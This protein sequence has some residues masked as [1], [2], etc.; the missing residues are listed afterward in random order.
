MRGIEIK[1]RKRRKAFEQYMT[2]FGIV[3]ILV[4]FCGISYGGYRAYVGYKIST[5][6][7]RLELIREQERN[8]RQC[9]R[10]KC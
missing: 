5:T 1:R 2:A 3:I 9:G 7:E 4:A 6:K 8:M 10:V